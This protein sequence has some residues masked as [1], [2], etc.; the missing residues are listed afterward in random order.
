MTTLT[1]NVGDTVTVINDDTTYTIISK[2]CNGWYELSSGKKVRTTFL[3][4]QKQQPEQTSSKQRDSSI[5][6]YN[7]ISIRE[8]GDKISEYLYTGIDWITLIKRRIV[9]LSRKI[10][11]Y[12]DMLSLEEY[13]NDI[14]IIGALQDEKTRL[15]KQMSQFNNIM[16]YSKEKMTN[17]VKSVD[18]LY[19]LF[20][21]NSNK[22]RTDVQIYLSK[23]VTSK[24]CYQYINDGYTRHFEVSN[25]L[26]WNIHE[27][28]SC[29]IEHVLLQSMLFMEKQ[30]RDEPKELMLRSII[31][32]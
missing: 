15:T 5:R 18:K 7:V 19:R 13:A 11:H 31:N 1:F 25:G 17:L 26:D 32:L 12:N 6:L 29:Y 20:E 9:W 22:R 14:N 30:Y 4:K 23:N 8:L 10:Q 2:T 28:L 3:R 16:K 27:R 21:D 24:K